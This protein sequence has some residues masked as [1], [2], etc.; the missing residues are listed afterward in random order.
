[1]KALAAHLVLK[2]SAIAPL[3]L[4]HA[5][6]AFVGQRLYRSNSRA[7]RI[8]RHN[9]SLCFPQLSEAELEQWTLDSLKELGKGG[10]ELGAMWQCT[11]ERAEQLTHAV[12]GM[13]LLEQA[14]AENRGV[15]LAVPHFGCWEILGT[16]LIGQGHS[17]SALFRPPRLASLE[18]PMREARTRF[19]AEIHPTTPKGVRQQMKALSRGEMVVLLPDQEP[20]Q[21]SGVFADF[22]KVPAL[23]M[24]LL[25]KMVKKKRVPV[26]FGAVKRLP[27]GKGYEIYF[28]KPDEPIYDDDPEVSAAALNRAVERCVDIAPV[29]YAWSYKRFLSRPDGSEMRY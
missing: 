24:T 12:H 18:K 9:L 11:P 21:D 4:S 15:M 27:G 14:R 2:L 16:Y 28:H 17:Y 25:N 26:I 23:T 8:T 5:L 20:S 29:Q 7:A 13:E 22:F 3:P 6:G 10:A 19:G 1:M